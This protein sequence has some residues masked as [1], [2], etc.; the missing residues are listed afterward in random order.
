MSVGGNLYPFPAITTGRP[1]MLRVVHNL[2]RDGFGG[3]DEV[4]KEGH[5]L[6]GIFDIYK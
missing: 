2:K 3:E 4:G 1:A 5:P 6:K